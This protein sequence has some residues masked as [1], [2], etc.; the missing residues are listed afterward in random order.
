[1]VGV[2]VGCIVEFLDCG[3]NVGRLPILQAILYNRQ[4]IRLALGWASARKRFPVVVDSLVETV[5][6]GD[7]GCLC[8][9]SKVSFDS[10]M[11]ELFPGLESRWSVERKWERAGRR[12]ITEIHLVYKWGIIL[13]MLFFTDSAWPRIQIEIKDFSSV[14]IS[15]HPAPP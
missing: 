15:T 2:D 7:V 1:M 13:P 10:G 8:K 12:G 4:A 9:G 6:E 5:A 14:A 3:E 11:G